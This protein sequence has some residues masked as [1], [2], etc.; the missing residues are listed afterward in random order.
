MTKQRIFPILFTTIMLIIFS[1]LAGACSAQRSPAYETD[2][3]GGAAPQ[4][5]VE[6]EG[7]SQARSSQGITPE[8][9][10]ERVVIKNAD[11]SIVVDDP[12]QSMDVVTQMADEM[13]GYVV[14]ANL[15]QK[16]LDNQV[17]VSQASVT[18][19][20][21]AERLNE[22]ITNIL[23]LTDQDPLRKDIES[24]DVTNEYVDLQSRLRNLEDTEEQLTEIMDNAK[25]TEDVLAVYNRLV[26]IRGEIEQVKGQIQYFEQSA[27]LSSISVELVPDEAVQPLS[28]GGWEPA[29]VAKDAVQALI[30]AMKFLVNVLIWIVIV[31]LPVLLVIFLIFIL[32][33][34]LVVRMWRSRRKRKQLVDSSPPPPAE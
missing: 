13:G 12:S 1:M 32:P 22:A 26:E 6:K 2:S 4:E 3:M 16:Q 33:I 31:A 28:I 10:I 24:Q 30:N 9:A 19:R 21:P 17:K 29:G 18:I 15:F 25:T 34:L 20:V 27:A 8:Q 14:S 7:V 23:A 11:L 5:A